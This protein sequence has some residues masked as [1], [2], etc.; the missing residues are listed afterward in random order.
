MNTQAKLTYR[1]SLL[2]AAAAAALMLSACGKHDDT[3]TAGQ[4]LDDTVAS[5]QQKSDEAKAKTEAEANKLG[6]KMANAADKTEAAAQDA[7][8]TASIKTEL[9]RDPS[10]S[11]LKINVDTKDR[12][13]ELH[14][15]A[16]DPASRDRATRIALAVKGVLSVDNKLVVPGNNA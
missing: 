9:A 15:T 12:L 4:K 5:V 6:D 2:A 7:T 8:I 10:L 13:V 16:P 14:G 3:R 11:A 1:T